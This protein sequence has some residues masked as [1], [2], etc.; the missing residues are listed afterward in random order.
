ML[1]AK[2]KLV[3]SVLRVQLPWQQEKSQKDLVG[4]LPLLHCIMS[5]DSSFFFDHRRIEVDCYLTG[6]FLKKREAGSIMI[7]FS[8]SDVSL[9][10]PCWAFKGRPLTPSIFCLLHLFLSGKLYIPE[11]IHSLLPS[12]SKSQFLICSDVSILCWALR[13][14]GR[15]R[16][17]F[18]GTYPCQASSYLK[19][20][21]CGALSTIQSF[22]I[23]I[24]IIF[25]IPKLSRYEVPVKT[26]SPHSQ[27]QKKADSVSTP[28]SVTSELKPYFA[29]GEVLAVRNEDGKSHQGIPCSC[30]VT[31]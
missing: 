20:C 1:K 14:R 27:G 2:Q 11:K 28:G 31:H 29:K 25:T 7:E 3:K 10:I 9:G 22:A 17:P 13:G 26:S 15:L 12:L 21:Q 19:R 23:F 8:V 5:K 18:C 4:M 30:G 16:L 24:Q 6:N